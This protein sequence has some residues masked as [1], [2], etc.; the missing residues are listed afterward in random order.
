MASSQSSAT[1]WW[2]AGAVAV[3]LLALLVMRARNEKQF[4]NKSNREVALTCTTDMA[5][6]YHVH[7][8]LSVVA[9]G[10]T[11]TIPANIGVK[12]GCMNSLHTH[13][14]SGKIHVEAPEQRDF[15]LADFFAVWDKPFTKDQL[16]EYRVDETHRI[17]MTVNGEE[18]TAYEQLVLRDGDQVVIYYE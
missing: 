1:G 6:Q 11:V 17:R 7:P 18:S 2:I 4:S 12:S 9:Q 10:N 15:T 13:D 3:V 8:N 14:T 16:L 5:T